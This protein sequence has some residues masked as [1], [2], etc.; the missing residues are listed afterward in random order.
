MIRFLFSAIFMISGLVI[1]TTSVV[2]N[3][4]CGY[5]LNRMQ[6]ASISDTFG[7]MLIIISLIIANGFDIT[8][9]KLLLVML[10]LWFANPVASH[11][12]A[13]TEIISDEKITEKCEVVHNDYI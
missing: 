9:L 11:F 6:A 8:S 10:F 5:I 12:L 4:R 7:A 2:G 1:F 13:R 3:F